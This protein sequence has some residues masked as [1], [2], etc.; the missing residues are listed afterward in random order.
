MSPTAIVLI[1]V[2]AIAHASWNLFGKQAAASRA[3]CFNWLLAACAAVLYAPVVAVAVALAHPRLTALSWL[4]LAGTGILHGGYFLFLQLGYARGDLSAVYPMGRGSGALLAALA[5]I[6][7]LGERPAP[8]GIA[9]I[10]VITAGIILL[11]LPQPGSVAVGRALAF[12]FATGA[13]IA[14]Y[15]IWDKYAVSQLRTPALLQG[16]A[17]FP[18][19]LVLYAPLV[20]RDRPGLAAVWRDFRPQVIGAAV[21]SPL[22]YFLV[23]IALAFTAVS[24]VA[25]AREISVLVGVLL[26]RRLL[27]EQGLARR[28]TAA[29]LIVTGIVAIAVG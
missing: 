3:V 14:T 8:V 6:M 11:G 16:Y 1:L 17:G 4:F 19:M 15:T 10:I 9:G 24:A 26:G 22:A 20:L 13:F 5:G 29:G 25:P 21:L 27:D 23:L 7:L 18:L 12:A 28:L 2:A